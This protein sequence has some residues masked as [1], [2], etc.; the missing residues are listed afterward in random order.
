MFPIFAICSIF[1]CWICVP[2][3]VIQAVHLRLIVLLA[4]NYVF[5]GESC[6]AWISCTILCGRICDTINHNILLDKLRCYGVRGIALDWFKSY[7]K[8][9]R[10]YRRL[11]Y[12]FESHGHRI[13]CTTRISARAPFVYTL[14]QWYTNLKLRSQ[15]LSLWSPEMCFSCILYVFNNIEIL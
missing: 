9:R 11:W 4:T 14:H 12:T 3:V 2:G 15:N 8:N 5:L 6:T 7:L 1:R 10:Q 13:W